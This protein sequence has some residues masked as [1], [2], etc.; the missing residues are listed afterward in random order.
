MTHAQEHAD[1]VEGARYDD[2]R[3]RY[4]S[5]RRDLEIYDLQT[6]EHDDYMNRVWAAGYGEDIDAYEADWKRTMQYADDTLG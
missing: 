2:V 3:E 5:E 6:Q 4:A 1:H